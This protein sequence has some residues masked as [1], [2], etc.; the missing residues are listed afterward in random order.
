MAAPDWF[1]DCSNLVVRHICRI[2]S[3]LIPLLFAVLVWYANRIEDKTEVM[4][5]SLVQIERNVDILID[6]QAVRGASPGTVAQ[7]NQE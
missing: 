3:V 1:T 5:K 2:A 4:Q 7:A 6:R